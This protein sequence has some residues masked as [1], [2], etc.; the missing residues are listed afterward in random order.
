[1]DSRNQSRQRSVHGAHHG[2]GQDPK[3]TVEASEHVNL[4]CMQRPGHKLTSLCR[5]ARYVVFAKEPVFNALRRRVSLPFTLLV[6]GKK[7]C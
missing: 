4:D 2:L 1:M 6:Q 5:N 7:S 3:T